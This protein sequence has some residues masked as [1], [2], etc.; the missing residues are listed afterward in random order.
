MKEKLTRNIGLKLISIVVAV[1]FWFAINN[2]I[3]PLVVMT[4]ENVPVTVLNRETMDSVNKLIEVTS[5]DKVSVRFR[6]KRSVANSL[7][8]KD[9]EAVADV[10]N[11]NEFNAVPI[12]VTCKAYGDA[13][14]EI[15][16]HATED[17]S[18]MLHLSLVDLVSRSFGVAVI[19]DGNVKDGFCIL[20]STVSPNLVTIRGSETILSKVSRVAI[21]VGVDGMSNSISQTCTVQAYDSEGNVVSSDSLHFSENQVKIDMEIVPTKEVE[22]YINP[23]GNPADGYYLKS[24]EYAPHYIT[25]AGT[26]ANLSRVTRLTLDCPIAGAAEATETSLDVRSA[27]RD[28]YG[29][30]IVL[31]NDSQKISVRA[32]IVPFEQ[33]TVTLPTDKIEIRQLP[34][35]LS[36]EI[37]ATA[38]EITFRGTEEAVR[39]IVSADVKAFI[40]CSFISKTGPYSSVVLYIEPVNGAKADPVK[41]DIVIKAEDTGEN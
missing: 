1:F 29:D 35:D 34:D 9:F 21:I 32:Q 2:V 24:V 17:G 39:N 14:L 27:L 40:D 37:D 13:E 41:L 33:K 19:T 28:L 25:L 31:V 6:A 16:S 23:V 12:I 11:K 18:T 38:V 15:L 20:N 7:S 4:V 8:V 30:N 5:G 3:D 26:A 10:T 36:C 22:V